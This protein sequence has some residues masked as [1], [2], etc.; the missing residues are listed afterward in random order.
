MTDEE[1]ELFRGLHVALNATNVALS[2]A[3][4]EIGVLKVRIEVLSV[5]MD[6]A[7]HQEWR[8]DERIT[9]LEAAR[10]RGEHPFLPAKEKMN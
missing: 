10:F 5:R 4:A 8:N 3:I 7:E 2:A 1:K 9:L 6:E